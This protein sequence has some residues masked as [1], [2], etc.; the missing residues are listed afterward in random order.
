[1]SRIIRKLWTSSPAQIVYGLKWR[2]NKRKD[3]DYSLDQILQSKKH[4]N[5]QY[6]I[7][8]WERYWRVIESKQ[9]DGA[10]I[11]FEF[12]DKV[13]FEL[14]CGPVFGWG[15]IALFQGADVYYYHEPALLRDVVESKQIREKYFSPLYDE[16]VANFGNRM[17]F[18]EFHEKVIHRCQP[19]DL[20]SPAQVDLILSNSVLEHIPRVEFQSLLDKLFLVSRPGGYYFHS[21]NFGSHKIGGSGFGSIYKTDVKLG[22]R[23]LNRLRKSEIEGMLQNS[24]FHPSHSTVYRSQVVDRN[25]IHK[26]WQAYT[27]KDLSA[28][29]VFF[30]GKKVE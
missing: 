3:W 1:M 30:V 26:S 7:D 21:V 10:K 2:L 16:L 14:G 28:R 20:K 13:I 29:V 6:L 8:R 15:P 18:T 5:A 12:R 24:G 23:H 4:M 22:F 19:G 27:D 17:S 9:G 25:A 11:H